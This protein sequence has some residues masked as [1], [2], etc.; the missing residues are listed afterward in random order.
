MPS[1][2]A[3]VTFVLPHDPDRAEAHLLIAPDGGMVV[4]GGVDHQAVMP[5]VGDQVGG[6]RADRIGA[7]TAPVY[8]R[9]EEDVDRGV[10]VVRVPLLG[11][12][13]HAHYAAAMQHR[14]SAGGFVERPVRRGVLITPYLAQW[15]R[16]AAGRPR[17]RPAPA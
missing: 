15:P 11:E 7:D 1:G 4:C 10:P 8:R 14:E 17:A 2:A 9:V 13:H 5:A 3:G 12:L 6:Q 16:S